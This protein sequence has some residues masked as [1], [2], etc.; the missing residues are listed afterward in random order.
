M[1]KGISKYDGK[2]K[3]GDKFGNWSVI[4][5]KIIIADGMKEYSIKVKCNCD[6]K[7]E[8]YVSCRKLKLGISWGCD[9]VRRKNN[10]CFWKGIGEIPGRYLNR[11]KCTAELKDIKM[12]V[13]KKYLWKLFLKQNRK[14]SLSGLNIGFGSSRNEDTTASLDRINSNKGYI[15]GNVWWVH[16]D[17]NIM[18]NDF[19]V[20]KF[21]ELC[22]MVIS[23]GN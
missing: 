6:R 16:K 12:S 11:I 1:E 20:E 14:C 5:P 10:S 19:S 7:T 18:K 22:K 15:K 13:N 23:Y 2:F 3:V 21:K 8:K 9:C 17:I 4:D